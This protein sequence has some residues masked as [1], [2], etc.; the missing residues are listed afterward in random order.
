MAWNIHYRDLQNNRDVLSAEV[1][2]VTGPNNVEISRDA[3]LAEKFPKRS[4][5]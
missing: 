5:T 1:Q 4:P 3:F 2:K